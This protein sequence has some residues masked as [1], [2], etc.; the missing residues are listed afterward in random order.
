MIAVK[1]KPAFVDLLRSPEIDFQLRQPY[2]SYRLARLHR[3]AESIPWNQFLSS[4]NVSEY[5]LWSSK[6]HLILTDATR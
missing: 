4:I 1:P 6:N 5:G 2:L 3:L